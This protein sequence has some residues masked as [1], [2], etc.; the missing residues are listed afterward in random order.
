M[1]TFL[2]VLVLTGIV[3]GIVL[4]VCYEEPVRFTIDL[5]ERSPYAYY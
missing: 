3:A 2:K 5:K 4:G 1:K